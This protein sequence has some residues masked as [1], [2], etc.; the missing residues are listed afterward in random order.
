MTPRMFATLVPGTTW[1]RTPAHPGTG[2]V[3]RLPR[4]TETPADGVWRRE[5]SARRMP[6]TFAMSA[7]DHACSRMA[8]AL[9]ATWWPRPTTWCRWR[10]WC[11]ASLERPQSP[12]PRCPPR[13]YCAR[14]AMQGHDWAVKSPKNPLPARIHPLLS[15]NTALIDD[16]TYAKFNNRPHSAPC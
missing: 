7:S 1:R 2:L 6:V 8:R 13:A 5:W 12:T 14:Q 4:P 16:S 3:A 11:W 9:R 10:S 15:N